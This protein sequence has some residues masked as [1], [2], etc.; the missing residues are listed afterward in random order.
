VPHT[1][2]HGIPEC[3]EVV[4]EHRPRRPT[5]KESAQMTDVVQ[6]SNTGVEIEACGIQTA[7]EEP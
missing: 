6:S 5:V 7:I 1:V 2:A 3:I 4:H